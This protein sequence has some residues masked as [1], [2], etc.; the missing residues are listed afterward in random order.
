[1]NYAI[2]IGASSGGIF[3]L[4]LVSIFLIRWYKKKTTKR[5]RRVGSAFLPADEASGNREKY[6]LSDKSEEKIIFCE[7]ADFWAKPAQGRSNEA[8][9]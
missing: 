6:E 5:P 1:M 3:V 7:E 8:F 9:N 4:A 2:I